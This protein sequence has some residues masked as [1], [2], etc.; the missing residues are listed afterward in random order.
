MGPAVPS[1]SLTLWPA[2]PPALSHGAHTGVT[3]GNQRVQV[4]L[5][6]AKGIQAAQHVVADR[7]VDSAKLEQVELEGLAVVRGGQEAR[8]AWDLA[9]VAGLGKLKQ[10]GKSLSAPARCVV[11]PGPPQSPS[12]VDRGLMGG[13]RWDDWRTRCHP[14]RVAQR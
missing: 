8:D 1:Q 13:A 9:G 12:P 14:W 2:Q 7:D 3:V 6:P 4:G 11:R 5:A 10:T